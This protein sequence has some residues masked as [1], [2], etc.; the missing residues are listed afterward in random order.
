MGN[1][2]HGAPTELVMLVVDQET[3]SERGLVIIHHNPTEDVRALEAITKEKH[4]TP[5]P[6]QVD[7]FQG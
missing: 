6:A 2:A 7:V 4:A 5:I 3:K 1:G